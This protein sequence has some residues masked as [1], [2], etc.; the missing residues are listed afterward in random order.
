MVVSAIHRKKTI[1]LWLH[2]QYIER[3]LS[4][5]GC[6]SNT[7]KEDYHCMVVSAIH[8]RKT[9]CMVVS[10]IHRKKTI[11]VWLC[12]QYIERRLSLYGCVSN[13]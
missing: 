2:Q 5:Y 8:G 10:A 11:M 1:I 13:T 6:V 4:L 3:I 7:W 9:H 12:Q